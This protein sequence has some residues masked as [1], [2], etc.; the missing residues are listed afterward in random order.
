MRILKATVLALLMLFIFG[1]TVLAVPSNI[2]V[3]TAKP[4]STSVVLKWT[5]VAGSTK[6]MV[7]YKTT[8]FPT[9]ATGAD[10]SIQ[11]YFAS[12]NTYV[13]TDLTPSSPS[14][15]LVSGTNYYYSAWA[16]DGANYSA[17]PCN[18]LITTLASLSASDSL[19]V[20]TMTTGF[21][22]QL[23]DSKTWYDNLQP[24][25]GFISNFASSWG[26]PKDNMNYA[27]GLGILLLIGVISYVK[28][29]SPALSIGIDLIVC[30]ILISMHMLPAYSVGV[31]IALGLGVWAM[32][33]FAMS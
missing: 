17:L 4:D 11:V 10:G 16:Y 13:Q 28:L 32:E 29:K 31:V 7:R 27:F 12:S 26:M 24:F 30:V 25:T 18:L 8:A 6:T 2:T 3:F 1:W 19:P 9:S 33:S 20:P 14:G 22:N 23:P 21:F 5:T 15:A